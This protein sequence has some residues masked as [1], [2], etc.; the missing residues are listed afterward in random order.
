MQLIIHGMLTDLTLIL[1]SSV[2]LLPLV[3]IAYFK[4]V[5]MY[6][7]NSRIRTSCS[8][9]SSLGEF[10]RPFPPDRTDGGWSYVAVTSLPPRP[11]R[12]YHG[13]P[14]AYFWR[15]SGLLALARQAGA[16]GRV[17]GNHCE[18]SEGVY[19]FWPLQPAATLC[20]SSLVVGY[21]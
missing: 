20:F 21:T 15:D 12:F 18:T 19:A 13:F 14:L 17:R 9:P 4:F 6:Y 8:M 16:R 7:E 10:S 11:S 2:I 3:L 1:R 5:S